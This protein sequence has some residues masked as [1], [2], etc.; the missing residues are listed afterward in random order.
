MIKEVL[1]AA[2]I[3]LLLAALLLPALGSKT[4]VNSRQAVSMS[5]MRQIGL[6]MAAYA[7]DFGEYPSDFAVLDEYVGGYG[8][9][10]VSPQ[11]EFRDGWTTLDKW[12]E[13][14][15]I[16]TADEIESVS[17]YVV[18]RWGETPSTEPKDILAYQKL[19][20]AIEKV[21]VLYMDTAVRAIPRDKAIELVRTAGHEPV[22]A[23]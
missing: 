5:N 22:W 14:D 7:E 15:Q 2:G 19:S 18:L 13:A 12:S 11:N 21:I 20:M 1:I 6:G 17:S 3:L 10:L 4:C 8:P 16:P 23:D 9:V